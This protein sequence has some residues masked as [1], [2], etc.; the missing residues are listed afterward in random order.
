M[1]ES[2]SPVR[3]CRVPGGPIASSPA[4]GEDGT[5]FIGSDDGR[6]HAVN[7]P[8]DDDVVDASPTPSDVL[9]QRRRRRPWSTRSGPCLSGS[10]RW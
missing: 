6:V 7:A 1:F 3:V 8:L 5:V 9:E 2:L 4:I 10:A